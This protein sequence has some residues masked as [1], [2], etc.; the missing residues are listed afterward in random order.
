MID[1]GALTD[2][3][4]SSVEASLASSGLTDPLVGDGVAPSLG[5]WIDGQPGS[6]LF[7]PYVVI[8]CS[9]AVPRYG[10]PASYTPSWAVAFALRSFGGSRPQAD[11]I[12]GYA[13][14]CVASLGKTAFG[15]AEEWKV[16]N[17]EWGSLGATVRVDATA[18]AFWQAFDAFTLV[19]DM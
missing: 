10:T 15:V 6:G 2:A 14:D 19:C 18:P 3:V 12:A 1:L 13:R 9:G 11:L 8:M 17:V 7:R 5:G 16:I 4:L